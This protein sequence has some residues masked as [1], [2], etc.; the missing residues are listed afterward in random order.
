MVIHMPDNS[1]PQQMSTK[2]FSILSGKNQSSFYQPSNQLCASHNPLPDPHVHGDVMQHLVHAH[3]QVV[4]DEHG[5]HSSCSLVQ[6]FPWWK[7]DL[8]STIEKLAAVV[9]DLY[10]DTLGIDSKESKGEDGLTKVEE[11]I[12]EDQLKIDTRELVHDK[13]PDTESSSN[14][15]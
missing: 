10:D 3:C 1:S 8:L 2:S 13:C 14:K 4:L 15:H 5:G 6:V 9:T 11:T 12:K 7:H